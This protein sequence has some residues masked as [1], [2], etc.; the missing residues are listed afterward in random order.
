VSLFSG[1]AGQPTG[2]FFKGQWDRYAAQKFRYT[3]YKQLCS[4]PE[5]QNI[6]LTPRRKPE[7]TQNVLNYLRSVIMGYLTNILKGNAPRFRS[8]LFP[9]EFPPKVV[10]F[11]AVRK[12]EFTLSTPPFKSLVS[13]TVLNPAKPIPSALCHGIP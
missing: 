11:L 5:K 3:T 6:L 8:Q 2:P 10:Y 12:E 4:I 7:M 13:K 1:V 9:K